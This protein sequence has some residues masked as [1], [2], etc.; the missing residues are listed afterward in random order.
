MIASLLNS[1]LSQNPSRPFLVDDD[2]QWTYKD[3]HIAVAILVKRLKKESTGTFACYL[4]DSSELIILMLAASCAGIP[5]VIINRDFS[6]EQVSTLVSDLDIALLFTESE[7]DSDIPCKQLNPYDKKELNFGES[8]PTSRLEERDSELLILTSGTTQKPRCVS[9]LWSDLLA[10]ISIG[11]ADLSERWMLAYKLN[12]FAGIQMLAHILSNQ[13]TL[14]LSPS[15]LVTDSLAT[16]SRRSV[17]HVSS[18]PTFW[19]FALNLLTAAS[20]PPALKQITLGSEPVSA[21]LLD[22]LALAFP[23]ARITHIYALTEAGSCVSVSDGR[24]GLPLAILD[25]PTDSAIQLRISNNELQVKTRHGMSGYRNSA[26]IAPVTSDGWLS[27]GDL[28]KVEGDRI[29]FMGRESEV[30]NVGGVKV[31][32][33][34]VEN[35]VL[36]QPGV[37]LARVFGQDNPVVGQIVAVELIVSE[38]FDPEVVEEDVRLACRVLPRHSMPRNVIIV[39]SINTNNL[40]LS[41]R[42]EQAL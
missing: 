1:A 34:E 33:L 18:T 42:E 39:D 36:A 24:P 2:G 15:T 3:V 8:V 10:Q 30:I 35:I 17:T 27:T 40:K 31:H 22:G 28:V 25:R 20:H 21:D 4:R 41:R 16:M 12:H 6:V 32:P 26:D 29:H 19:R 7:F 5:L 11:K 9:Y 14:V 13:S 23:K 37:K 38:G